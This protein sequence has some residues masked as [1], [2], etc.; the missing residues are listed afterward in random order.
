MTY[1]MSASAERRV[2]YAL[3]L[4]CRRF[5][6][7]LADKSYLA[8]VREVDLAGRSG[9]SRETVSREFHKPKQRGWVKLEKDGIRVFNLDDLE[10]RIGAIQ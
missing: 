1:L 5:G 8:P 6:R 2:M 10:A 3:S 9:L 4:E 7:L